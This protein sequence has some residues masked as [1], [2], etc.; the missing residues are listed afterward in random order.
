MSF[1]YFKILEKKNF[2]SGKNNNK[3]VDRG[4]YVYD[5]SHLVSEG[6]V[7]K[8]GQ[9]LGPLHRH[10]EQPGRGLEHVLGAGRV[11]SHVVL[12]G[13]SLRLVARHVD[14]LVNWGGQR[15]RRGQ[16]L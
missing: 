3:N 9:V 1:F 8:H 4:R 10:E 7:R 6:Q 2:Q 11:E 13:G 16:A 14:V 12:R 5:A 15:G